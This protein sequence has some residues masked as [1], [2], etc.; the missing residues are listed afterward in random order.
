[1]ACAAAPDFRDLAPQANC[2]EAVHGE[3]LEL[4]LK[5][6]RKSTARFSWICVRWA[7]ARRPGLVW[8]IILIPSYVLGGPGSMVGNLRAV[9]IEFDSQA[10]PCGDQV[11]W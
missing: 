4:S 5:V 8:G 9:E 6:Q 2:A 7:E 1:M 3:H 11:P 10:W